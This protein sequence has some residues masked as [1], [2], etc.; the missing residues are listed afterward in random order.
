MQTGTCVL[1]GTC[2][3]N[4]RTLG[5]GRFRTEQKITVMLLCLL[6]GNKKCSKKETVLTCCLSTLGSSVRDGCLFRGGS[7]FTSLRRKL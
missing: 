3:L 2:T 4:L 1:S 6:S 7:A 5:E